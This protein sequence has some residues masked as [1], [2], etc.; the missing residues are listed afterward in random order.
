MRPTPKKT[1]VLSAGGTGGHLFPA[2]ALAAELLTRGYKVVILTDKRGEAFKSL[3]SDVEIFTVKAA[4]LKSGI[5]SKVRAVADMG[6]GIFQ[7]MRLLRKYKPDAVVG[8]GGY[9]SFPG[10]FAAQ[11][12]GIPTILHEQNGV[13]GKANH[14]LAKGSDD[15]ATSL[16]DTKGIAPELQPRVTTTG[17]P[18]RKAI[19]DAANKPYPD[20]DSDIRILVTGGS[21]ASQSL[22]EVIPEAMSLLTAAHK[23]R[24]FV[25]HQCRENDLDITTKRYQKSGVR[26]EIKTFFNDM[27][28]RLSSCHLFIGRSGASTVAEMAAMGRPSIFIPD[29][30]HADLQQK[31]N[32]E[33]LE[34]AGGAWIML[35]QDFTPKS[36]ADKLT[37]MLDTPQILV[38][39]AVAAKTCGKT[40]ATARLADVVE[41]RIEKS[42][43]LKP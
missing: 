23:K 25:M 31:F 21:Q 5:L 9:P 15:I 16:P 42:G 34:K 35:H 32:A 28:E 3:G 39:A 7:A 30:R 36:L 18:V 29:P 2:E 33:P 43:K 8:F 20:M 12:M 37:A 1:V 11:K 38:N 26:A 27:A 24:L 14:F 4:Y 22:S 40:D 19:I 17:N 13:L 41:Q 10:L 6:V